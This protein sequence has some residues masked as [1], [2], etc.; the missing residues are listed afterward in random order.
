MGSVYK[1][2]LRP[3]D[4]DGS[5]EKLRSVWSLGHDTGSLEPEKRGPGS[6]RLELHDYPLESEELCRLNTSFFETV[7]RRAGAADAE[8]RHIRCRARGAPF[9]VWDVTWSAG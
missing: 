3:G 1:V 2:L 9:C 6:G 8:L 7:L 4:P 5:F